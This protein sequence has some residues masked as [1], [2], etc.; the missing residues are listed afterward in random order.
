MKKVFLSLAVIASVSLF[1]CGNKAEKA[2]EAAA[3]EAQTE[4]VAEEPAQCDSTAC[5]SACVV[6]EVVEV[7]EAPAAE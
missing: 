6:E 4:A 5:D 3:E 1:S 7:A 2:E